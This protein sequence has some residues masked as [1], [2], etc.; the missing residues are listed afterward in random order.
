MAFY[1]EN[2]LDSDKVWDIWRVEGPSLVWHFPAHPTFMP[3]L[4]SVSGPSACS[5]P[6][7]GVTFCVFAVYNRLKVPKEYRVYP[8]AKHWVDTSHD[9]AR[10]K[11]I[12]SYF[13]Q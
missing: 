1:Q 3:T 6:N 8:H 4:M 10:R 9:D 13:S 12:W 11:W 2:D 5:R 7:R